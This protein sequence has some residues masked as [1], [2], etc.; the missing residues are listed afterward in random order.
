[1]ATDTWIGREL[2]GYRIQRPIGR[3]GMGVVYLAE[4]VRLGRRVALKL[5]SGE[6]SDDAQFRERFVRE[7]RLAA[8]LEHPNIVPIHAAGESDGF[9]FLAMRFIEGRDLRALIAEDGPLPVHRA[10]RIVMQM[11]SALDAAHARGLVHRDV[12]PANVLVSQVDG[13]DHCYLTDFGLA[14]QASSLSGLTVTGHIMGTVDYL[15]PEVIAGMPADAWSDQYSLGCVLYECLTTRP[16]FQRASD[17]AT[18][19]AHMQG[20]APRLELG[21]DFGAYDSAA[22]VALSKDPA[23]RYPTCGAFAEALRGASP[24]R[25]PE[26]RP[27]RRVKL[28]LSGLL[29]AAIVATAAVT[30]RVAGS[31]G[32][33]TART[34][35]ANSVVVLDPRTGRV[36]GDPIPV[37]RAPTQVVASGNAVWV[38]N[39]AGRSLTWIDA[40]TRTAVAT[41]PLHATPTSIA[42]GRRG[43]VWVDEGLARSLKEYV[44]RTAGT[45]DNPVTVSIPGCCPGPSS[46]VVDG[47]SLWVGDAEGIRRVDLRDP[48]IPHWSTPMYSRPAAGAGVLGGQGDPY[49]SDGW[50]EVIKVDPVYGG[51]TPA[52]P[53]PGDP[54]SLLSDE[55]YLWYGLSAD[56]AVQRVGEFGSGPRLSV[57]MQEPVGLAK[58]DGQI[59]AA[60]ATGSVSVLQGVAALHAHQVLRIGGR[61]SSMTA[62]H[63]ELWVSIEPRS[64]ARA[65]Q[66]MIAYRNTGTD[67]T[68]IRSASAIGKAHVI[69]KTGWPSMLDWS[70]DGRRFVYVAAPSG[71]DS[72]FVAT[73]NG[74]SDVR[75]TRPP[76]GPGEFG[77]SWSPTGSW[78]AVWRDVRDQLPGGVTPENQLL[79]MHPDGSGRHTIA[80][81]RPPFLILAQLD[82]SPD[83]RQLAIEEPGQG[84]DGPLA[85]IPEAGGRPHRL[86]VFPV[87]SARWS[88]DGTRVA[89]LSSIDG[90]GVYV[91]GIDGRNT[92]KLAPVPAIDF[93]GPGT[94][95]WSPDGRELAYA[96]YGGGDGVHVIYADGSGDTR[97]VSGA[98]FPAWRPYT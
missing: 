27:G 38:A 61:L 83:G 57:P 17:A 95:T 91:T 59:W 7:S 3:G 86:T 6:L 77:P 55:G 18:L 44:P 25:P 92:R 73:A 35:P 37:G 78:I 89:Y 1:L 94:V 42:A 87:W 65:A 88:P 62:S 39:A 20:D 32:H 9:L 67:N 98:E 10:T 80:T 46:V 34:P 64:A 74:K 53:T 79:V 72:T 28:A 50:D 68:E 93:G 97:V 29:L 2:A 12:K 60:G 31:S 4:D 63:G 96:G 26:F 56:N 51:S 5:L 70:P 76:F 8:S 69:A 16:P 54:T 36:V 15:A 22:G 33:G 81:T 85:V 84:S 82:W 19:W 23:R 41:I 66:G 48:A 90:P 47:R 52:N 14:K 49:F 13:E 58:V 30:A 11:A 24:G 21:E 75:L 71:N 45:Y 43:A 40:R